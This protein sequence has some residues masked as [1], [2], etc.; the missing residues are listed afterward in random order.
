MGFLTRKRWPSSLRHLGNLA[1]IQIPL[2][3]SGTAKSLA[4]RSRLTPSA[5][6]VAFASYE[7]YPT[8]EALQRRVEITH[9]RFKDRSFV[10]RVVNSGLSDEETMAKYAEA[11]REFGSHPDSFLAIGHGEVVGW[12]E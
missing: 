3:R 1:D 6:G 7:T 4:G 9:S 5:C 12:K 11:F 8:P 2:W 10:D